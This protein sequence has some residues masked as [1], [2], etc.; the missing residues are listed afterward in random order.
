MPETDW[1]PVFDEHTSEDEVAG[2]VA[3]VKR[4]PRRRDALVR[5]L[6]EQNPLYLN[7]GANEVIRLRGYVLA[8]FE[9]TGMPEAALPYVLEELENGRDAYLVAAAAKALRSFDRPTTE[10]LPFLFKAVENIKYADDTLTFESYRPRWPAAHPTTALKELFITFGCLGAHARS[11]V[12]DLENLLENRRDAFSASVRAEIERAVE[13]IRADETDIGADCCTLP[14]NLNL[15]AER[16][17]RGRPTPASMAAVEFEDQDGNVLTFSDFFS[18]R[19]SIVVFFYSR[20]D[21]PHKCSLTVTKLAR[22]Q[23]AIE[24][25]GLDGQ[26]KTAAITYDPAYDL[27]PRLKAYGQNRGVRFGADKRML[28]SRNNFKELENYFDSGVS[29]IG[30]IVNRHRIE[31]FI[32]DDKGGI[33]YAF[34]RLQWEVREV[35]DLAA[36]LLENAHRPAQTAKPLKVAAPPPAYARTV[37]NSILNAAPPLLLAFF[38]KCPLC[39]A[40]Y[41]SAF[42][43]T[44]LQG[45]PYSPW[46]LYVLIILM[47]S[48]LVLVYRRAT[49][50]KEFAAFYLALSG[51]LIALVSNLYLRLDYASYLGAAMIFSGSLLSSL[52]SKR[53]FLLLPLINRGQNGVGE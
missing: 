31:L 24:E 50:M 41:L 39:W 23:Q 40:A 15:L 42:G 13:R 10:L 43:I 48:N 1:E 34:T 47:L 19:P 35:L 33:A 52:P 6:P 9:Q 30:S 46:A 28:R 8:A 25:A 32:L 18:R 38:P 45:I 20:C 14:K 2:F 36:S 5:L 12:A 26:L 17:R 27:P 53:N 16:F 11:A 44:G 4:S 37:S 49:R 21:N 29:F 51:T 3:A 7:R 22:L